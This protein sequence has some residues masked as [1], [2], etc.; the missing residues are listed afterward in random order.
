MQT[1]GNHPPSLST[2]FEAPA[3]MRGEAGI[4]CGLSADAGFLDIALERFTRLTSGQ[5]AAE[6]K[7]RLALVL[8]PSA[9]QIMPDSAP[10]MLHL[11]L[12]SV[13]PTFGLLHAKVALLL[14]RGSADP[15]THSWVLRLVVGTGNWTFQTVRESIDLFWTIDLK[16]D[17]LTTLD[18]SIRDDARD[19]VAAWRFFS[20]I[21]RECC[22]VSTEPSI[23]R[24]D[25]KTLN[26]I[27]ERIVQADSIASRRGKPRFTDNRGTSLVKQFTER[28]A[29]QPPTAKFNYLAVGSGFFSEGK[30]SDGSENGALKILETLR[31]TLNKD[32][33]LTRNAE[34]DLFVNPEECQGVAAAGPALRELKWSIRPPAYFGEATKR[35]LHAK[36]V[37]CAVDNGKASQSWI[38]L[39][40]GNITRQGFTS[41]AG[42][43]NLEAGVMFRPGTLLWAPERRRGKGEPAVSDLL[44]VQWE[45]ELLDKGQLKAGKGFEHKEPAFLAPPIPFLR[46]KQHD[47]GGWLMPGEPNELAEGHVALID[48]H[49]KEC[50]LQ[51]GHFYWDGEQPRLVEI[52]WNDG[53]RAI[54]PVI[55]SDGRIAA[56]PLPPRR[57]DELWAEL[58]GFPEPPDLDDDNDDPETDEPGDQRTPEP[59]SKGSGD[60]T[61]LRS[62]MILVEK[63]ASR[64]QSLNQ[65][66]WPAWCSRLE[67]TLLRAAKTMDVGE[68]RRLGVNP[69]SPLRQAAFQPAFAQL[70]GPEQSSYLKAL[71]AIEA[72]WDVEILRHIGEPR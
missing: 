67:Q 13:R 61:L 58:D 70:D 50:S 29:A 63:I 42:S 46:W 44:P 20:W 65:T 15:G 36:F 2:L 26:A 62:T 1:S 47:T 24:D 41:A 51:D 38:Y 49:G 14:F 33:L 12:R 43:G 57:I 72:A 9:P 17:D 53:L 31:T 52:R 59:H 37:F 30:D 34:C 10:G 54:L 18:R 28:L 68:F 40:S 11:P 32:N 6:G 4:V 60:V 7:I 5:R 3:N 21:L 64:Q 71:S 45:D 56:L 27:A 69:L 25:L 48:T 22:G 66:D 55:G 35:F 8:D 16:S 19:C 39:G 23:V